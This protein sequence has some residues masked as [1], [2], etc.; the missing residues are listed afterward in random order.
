MNRQALLIG[1][2]GRLDTDSYLGGVARDLENYNR[3]LRSPLGGAWYSHEIT[4]LDDP[5]AT[6]VRTH[7]RLLGTPDY[8]FVL[9]SGHGY[10]A[11]NRRSTIVCLRNDEEIDST[12]LC[13][14]ASKHTLMLDCCRVVARTMITEDA[15]A[16][17]DAT[18]RRFGASNCRR[19]YDKEIEA[20][21]SGLIVLHSCDVGETSGDDSRRGGYFAYSLIDAAETWGENNRT[22]LSKFYDSFSVPSGYDDASKAVKRMTSSRQNPQI[23]KPR[24]SPYFPL[25][26]VAS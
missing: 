14:G 17:M 13:S 7:L 12:E 4:T 3:F 11:A 1:S 6:T 26:I 8:S 2:P 20:S 22:D 18:A 9:F 24:S 23:E 21:P 10:F 5:S 15:L 25:A 16:K 19:Y